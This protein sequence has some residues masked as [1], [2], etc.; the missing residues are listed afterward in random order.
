MTEQPL[1]LEQADL[2]TLVGNLLLENALLRK[3]LAAAALPTTT[4]NEEGSA[5]QPVTK[6]A[7]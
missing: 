2:A 7:R 6:P 1:G 5:V 3:A 4:S